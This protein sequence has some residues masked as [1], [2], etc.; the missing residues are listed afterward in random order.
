MTVR[1]RGHVA[2]CGAGAAHSHSSSALS[3]IS[4]FLVDCPK[5]AEIPYLRSTRNLLL[6]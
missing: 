6:D 5:L 2:C 3:D 4:F 1:S